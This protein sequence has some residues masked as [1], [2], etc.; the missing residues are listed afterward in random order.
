MNSTLIAIMVIASSF[1]IIG[2]VLYIRSLMKRKAEELKEQRN[3]K[4][5]HG[6]GDMNFIEGDSDIFTEYDNDRFGC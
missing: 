5:N 4:R 2:I 1:A 3:L 6:L